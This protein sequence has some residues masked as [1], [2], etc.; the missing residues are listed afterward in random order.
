M[1]QGEQ[2]WQANALRA[3]LQF[4]ISNGRL[5]QT[6]VRALWHG[7]TAYLDTGKYRQC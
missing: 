2:S 5:L 1:T 3:I 7:P 6:E 4:L